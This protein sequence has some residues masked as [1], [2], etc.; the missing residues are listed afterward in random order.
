MNIYN[1]SSEFFVESPSLLMGRAKL[2]NQYKR[3]YAITVLI[4]CTHLGAINYISKCYGERVSGIQITSQP[5]FTNCKYHVP[6][7]QILAYSGFILEFDFAAGASLL[8][9]GFIRGKS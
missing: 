2:Y 1:R 3:H 9:L 8:I 5:G 6:G 7:E 4:S